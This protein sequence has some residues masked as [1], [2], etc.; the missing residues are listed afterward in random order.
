MGWICRNERGRVIWAGAKAMP[1]LN[2]SIKTEAE[3]MLWAV[4]TMVRFGYNKVIF[5]SDSLSLVRMMTGKEEVWPILQPTINAIFLSLQ[6]IHEKS[7]EF[8]PRR[9]N[10]TADRLANE[11]FTFEFNVSKLYYVVPLWLQRSVE[12]DIHSMQNSR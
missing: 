2:S 12:L 11:T 1:R 10:K 3:A 7:I 6:Q 8:Y 4:E 9:G 5:E